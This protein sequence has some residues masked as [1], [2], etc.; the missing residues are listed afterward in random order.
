MHEEVQVQRLGLAEQVDLGRGRV[1]QEQHV[2]FVNGLESANGRAVEG[3]AVLEDALVE[4]RN[5]DCEVLHDA[6]QVT[7]PDVDKFD[8]LV[9]GEFEDVVGRRFRH[10]MLLYLVRSAA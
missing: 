8:F 3:Q 1:R 5:R 7:E 10:R 9:L 6:G 2:G 4:K